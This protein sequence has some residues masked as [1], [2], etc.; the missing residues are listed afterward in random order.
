[1]KTLRH[2]LTTLSL[3]LGLLLTGAASL[4]LGGCQDDLFPGGPGGENAETR[5][6]EM[7]TP[8]PLQLDG[9]YWVAKRRVP[10]VGVGRV[11]DDIGSSL[12][13]V[14]SYSTGNGLECMFDD[15]LD[16]CAELKDGIAEA[17]LIAGAVVSVKDIYHTYKG[18]QTVGFVIKNTTNQVL[19]VEVLKT[20]FIMTYLDGKWQE[21]IKSDNDTENGVLKL[22]LLSPANSDKQTITATAEKPFDEIRLC[23]GGVGVGVLSSMQI[24][25]AFV[26][27]NEEVVITHDNYPQATIEKKGNWGLVG[28]FDNPERF[29]YPDEEGPSYGLAIVDYPILE[30]DLGGESIPAG[31]EFGFKMTTGGLVQL[32]L[33]NQTKLEYTYSDG[34]SATTTIA[35]NGI[36]IGLLSG[37]G[38]TI[39][40]FAKDKNKAISK[41]KLSL[42]F[43]V[44]GDLFS[45][46]TIS[47][48]YY[49]DPVKIDPSYYF[50]IGNDTISNSSYRLPKPEEG[51]VKYEFLYSYPS[52]IAAVEDETIIQDDGNG[53]L[54]T[55]NTGYKALV[56]MTE[57]ATYYMKATYTA[58]NT[59]RE[60]SN[61][62]E[63]IEYYFSI[64]R[65]TKEMPTCH[66]PITRAMYDKVALASF[67]GMQG[68]LLCIGSSNASVDSEHGGDNVIDANTNN[69]AGTIGKI[70]VAGQTGIVAVN[71][72]EEIGKANEKMQV[73]FV[74][75][76]TKEFLDLNVLKLFNIRVLDKERKVIA[77]GV[78]TQNEGIGIGLLSGSG[79]KLRYSIEVDQPFQYVELYTGAGVNVELS[80]LRVYYAFWENISDADC[81]ES[82]KEFIPGDACIELL[83]TQRNNAEINYKTTYSPATAS[84][85]AFSF[86]SLFGAIDGSR[87]TAAV[88][89]V[90]VDVGGAVTLG[91]KFD[92][93]KAGQSVGVILRKQTGLIDLDLLTKNVQLQ[94]FAGGDGDAYSAS[95]IEGGGFTTADVKVIG[96]G[97][98]Y[99]LEVTPIKDFDRIV[100]TFNSGLATVFDNYEVY[101]IYY[102]PDSDNDGIPDC[103]ENPIER[104]DGISMTVE[105][106]DICVNE[107]MTIHAERGIGA[108]AE[109]TNYYLQCSAAGKAPVVIP[110]VITT[111]GYLQATDGHSLQLSEYGYYA[112]RLYDNANCEG[113]S[114]GDA[115]TIAVHSLQTSWNGNA[116]NHKWNDWDNWEDGA[117]WT[118]TNVII[119]GD[120]GD[121]YPILSAN[122]TN[123]CANLYIE[124]GG[125]LVNSF[126][127]DY[128]LAW[129]DVELDE[130][131]YYMLTSPLKAT[132]SGDWFINSSISNLEAFVQLNSN[133]YPEKRSNPTV[134][135]RLWSAN[136]PVKNPSGYQ[137]KDEVAPDETHWTPPYNGV[138]QEYGLGMGF[139]LMV[140]GGS[141]DNT[142]RF[143]K[144]HME[145]NYFNLA[146]SPTGEKDA[147]SRET[148][149]I[150]RFIYE[151]GENNTATDGTITVPV[152]KPEEDDVTACLVGNPFVAHVNLASFMQQNGIGEVKV[153]DGNENNSLILVDGQLVSSGSLLTYI[154]PMESFFVMNY[155]G[156]EV[157]Y[158][159]DMLT[160]GG[161]TRTRSAAP[162]PAVLRLAAT[163]DGHT[164][165]ALLRVSPTASAG[166]APGEDTKLLVEGEARPAVAIYTVAD[167]R[168]LDI[169]QVPADVRRIPL[170]F[171]L[172][173]GGKADIRLTPQFTDPEWSDWFLLDLRTG[174]RRRLTPAAID[175]HDV[176]NGSSRYVLVK[177]E[178]E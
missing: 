49:R 68:C 6:E 100:I 110:V 159:A 5:A 16:N 108:S 30:L 12:I 47:Y 156:N 107:D 167:G 36:G 162:A 161:E 131:R 128:D 1:M 77:T 113:E 144:T 72:G 119:P 136:A 141:G 20:F 76:T 67:D 96:S 93:L 71:A 140:K 85:N 99:A 57:D 84:I 65:E 138:A 89:P 137:A 147:I 91:I 62:G 122:E 112:L 121:N 87:N 9:E 157:T 132:F 130:N 118:C 11:A 32:D 25:Y 134:Y 154:K 54:S 60:G 83:S 176:E 44:V 117:P 178:G 109:Q 102:R 114:E 39:C 19:N 127:L 33:F 133:S 129:V 38:Q 42:G 169:Q 8:G 3:G 148:E 126:Y 48:A 175:L 168:A 51:A 79:D 146:G 164:A 104:N 66:T 74:L 103:S 101:G 135:Q 151:G 170:G 10:L 46:G 63:Q 165:H 23:T 92:K 59:T 7:E 149:A 81:A 155:T 158:T 13:K 152:Q 124:D 31:R 17:D 50:G 98:K 174:Q 29:W 123:V 143:P 82:S 37:G 41:M 139:S 14:A 111:E 45:G 28:V 106:N 166:V 171:Y 115:C 2:T 86:A 4:T 88:V 56:G 163:L 90:G 53:N 55:T 69:Y 22:N 75:Q 70:S 142:F 52:V 145:Y 40:T 18:G 27:E 15:N 94:A 24:Y 73:G 153:F 177:N 173:G 58:P 125:Q 150:G 43:S 64:T 120:L 26:G 97:D 160:A 105:T 35:Q 80:A 61:T 21:T 95:N 34:E 172:P 78:A 116:D